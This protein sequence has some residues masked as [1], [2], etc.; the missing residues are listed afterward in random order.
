MRPTLRDGA[1]R[2]HALA[3]RAASSDAKD[4]CGNKRVGGLPRVHGDLEEGQEKPRRSLEEEHAARQGKVRGIKAQGCSKSSSGG[5]LTVLRGILLHILRLIAI[6]AVFI[7]VATVM[8]I[9]AIWLCRTPWGGQVVFWCGP[10]SC[11]FWALVFHVF[12]GSRCWHGR[13]AVL[14]WR[15]ERGG[16]LMSSLKSTVLMF[17]CLFASYAL[18]FGYVFLVRPSP[19][20][21]QFLPA[22]TYAPAALALWS[23]ARG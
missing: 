13:G 10:W 15:E 1:G 19:S 18:E 17:G 3:L 14:A 12:V 11:C 20:A 23:A 6:A 22:A 9:A 8:P 7:P 5:F 4:P 21:L 2:T 16:Y